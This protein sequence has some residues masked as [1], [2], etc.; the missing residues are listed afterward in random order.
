MLL[1][2]TLLC[3][4][5]RQTPARKA[6]SPARAP[7]E[8]SSPSTG[9]LTEIDVIFTIRPKPRAD[10]SSMTPLIISIG[11]I[12]FIVTPSVMASRSSS[13]KSR[14]GGP[15]LLLIRMSAPG[16]ASSSA[17]WHCGSE[18]LP[19]T[20]ITSISGARCRISCAVVASTLSSRP[21]NVTCT[22]FLAS[23]MAQAL[24]RPLLEAQTMALRPFMPRSMMPSPKV[25]M[26]CI[27]TG[28]SL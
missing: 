3:A 2:V 19:A 23:E 7:L 20:V 10:M 21:F 12:I 6:V 1:I 16:V 14:K 11:V 24:P 27:T 15:P 18:T 25:Q 4:T 17:C 28:G 26:G 13:R 9:F 5:D 8:R 22:P